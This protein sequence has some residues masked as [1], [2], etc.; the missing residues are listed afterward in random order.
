[1]ILWYSMI[2]GLY[3]FPVCQFIIFVCSANEVVVYRMRRWACSHAPVSTGWMSEVRS[4]TEL[5]R[6]NT[7]ARCSQSPRLRSQWAPARRDPAT[8]G[9]NGKPTAKIFCQT[10]T[11]RERERERET[12]RY[13]MNS[14]FYS[15]PTISLTMPKNAFRYVKLFLKI[16]SYL[17]KT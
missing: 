3:L 14:W 15:S 5:R 2:V 9:S 1:M 8:W 17:D 10:H 13:I 16:T 6:R 7:V 4:A 12:K 11:Q